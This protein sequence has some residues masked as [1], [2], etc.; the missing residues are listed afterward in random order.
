MESKMKTKNGMWPFIRIKEILE[1][2]ELTQKELAE[3]IGE[4]P[5]QVNKW[6]NGVEPCLSTLGRIA[7]TLGVKLADLVWLAG[8]DAEFGV[9]NVV[10]IRGEIVGTI[11]K[12]PEELMDVLREYY[13]W[14]DEEVKGVKVISQDFNKGEIVLGCMGEN[15]SDAFITWAKKARDDMYRL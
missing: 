2:K 14:T 15:S 9:H 13:R 12:K 7:I 6:V 11:S 8:D 10:Y 4:T 5:Q 3:M 1:E